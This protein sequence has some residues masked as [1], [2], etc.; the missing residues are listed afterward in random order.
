MGSRVEGQEV[1]TGNGVTGTF[2]RIL[3]EGGMC[4]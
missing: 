3:E 1:E 4:A 2:R